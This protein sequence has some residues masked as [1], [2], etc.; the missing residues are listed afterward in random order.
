MAEFD[1]IASYYDAMYSDR[2]DDVVFYVNLVQELGGPVLECGC[3][4]GRILFPI[5]E[6]GIEICGIDQSEAMLN[7]ARQKLQDFGSDARGRV[8]LLHQDMRDFALKR[9]FKVCIVPFRAFLHLLTVADQDKALRRIH[10]H[11]QS[12]GHLIVDIFAPSHQLLSQDTAT[13][14]VEQRHNEETGRNFAI[15]DHVRYDHA[16]QLLHVERYFEEL[17]DDGV[18]RRK[19]MPFSMRYIFRYE[20][21][22][23]LEKNGFQLQDV[24]GYFDRRPYDYKSGEMIFVA[25]KFE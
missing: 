15:L 14:R 3:G 17:E 22:A 13:M 20:M 11:L 12:K 16:N 19:V 7:I 6:S 25:E 24:Y 4:T 21:Q 9:S 2:K 18:V 23:R 1:Q 10:Q 5:A 8:Q